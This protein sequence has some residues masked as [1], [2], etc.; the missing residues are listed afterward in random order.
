MAASRDEIEEARRWVSTAGF[1][2]RGV[3]LEAI[4][5]L[6]REISAAQVL[7]TSVECGGTWTRRLSSDVQPSANP[8]WVWV[9]E[10]K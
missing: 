2:H 7:V 9:K 6:V 8:D 4:G 3:I 1:P 10:P 5:A